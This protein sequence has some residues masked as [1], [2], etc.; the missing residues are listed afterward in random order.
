MATAITEG[1]TL[2]TARLASAIARREAD[3]LKRA[4]APDR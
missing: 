1:A 2:P 3:A 4:T